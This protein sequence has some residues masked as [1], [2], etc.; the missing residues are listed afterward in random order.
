M[1]SFRSS[2][3][4][5]FLAKVVSDITF[6]R[7][8]IGGRRYSRGV[9]DTTPPGVPQGVQLVPGDTTI[10]VSWVY[11]TDADSGI[12]SALLQISPNGVDQWSTSVQIDYPTATY[13]FTGLTSSTPYY[14]RIAAQD[15]AP[16]ANVSSW[17]TP[18]V[19]TTTA[20]LSDLQPGRIDIVP[21]SAATAE[22][23]GFHI[24]VARTGA[25]PQ[26]ALTQADWAFSGFTNGTPSPPNG[27]LEWAEGEN[28]SQYITSTAGL[29]TANELGSFKIFNVRTPG[30]TLQATK[31]ADTIPV[32]VYDVG[33]GAKKWNPGHYMMQTTIDSYSTAIINEIAAMPNCLGAKH[34]IGWNTLEP[35]QGNYDFTFTDTLFGLLKAAGKRFVLEVAMESYNNQN[36]IPTY[37]TTL[38]NG[39]GGYYRKVNTPGVQAKVYLPA[40]M[41]RVKA[42]AAAI[43]NRYDTDPKFE[44]VVFQDESVLLEATTQSDYSESLWV[45]QFSDLITSLPTYFKESNCWVGFNFG[46]SNK[47]NLVTLVDAMVASGCG[48]TGPDS[49]VDSDDNT[50]QGDKVVRGYRWNGS[51]WVL[52]GPDRRG[53]IPIAHDTQGPEMGGKENVV[54][55]T[56]LTIYNIQYNTHKENHSFW[57]YHNFQTP[58]NPPTDLYWDNTKSYAVSPTSGMDI[59][60]FINSGTYP[61]R[62]TSPSVYGS[63]I[64]GG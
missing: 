60:T 14:V 48:V 59:K 44:G 36:P 41:A 55:Y 61:T 38:A 12:K 21:T 22:G 35:T 40:V 15:A 33:T 27:Y 25:G 3:W 53:V 13:Q 32:Q 4:F 29:V 31:G 10:D 1:E 2:N 64:T 43:A 20:S 49:Y 5:K 45:T 37:L 39:G 30:S 18:Q 9:P 26:G 52:T 58:P 57:L 6:A 28:S 7:P 11:P 63:V 42:L 51:S 8:I 16:A 19:I 24:E 50:T 54:A 34:R 56:I 62:S 47:A 17:T 23:T 46:F